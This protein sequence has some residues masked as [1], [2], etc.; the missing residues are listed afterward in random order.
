MRAERGFD[1][2]GV[3]LDLPAP[4][5]DRAVGLFVEYGLTDR[6][7]LRGKG[8]WQSGEDAFVDYD[9]RGPLE[10]GLVWQAWRDESNAL[11][12]AASYANGGEG[13]NAGYALPGQG[14]HDWE[15]RVA[16]GRSFG[17]TWAT[18]PI[19]V[20]AQ[21]AR[22]LRDGL[23]DE[24]RLDLT[25]GS[26]FAPDWMGLTQAYGGEADGGSRWL[27]TEASLVRDF[28]PWSVQAGWRNTATGRETPE[29]SGPLIALW[30]RF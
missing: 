20:E 1:P 27:T 9:G 18:P 21:V 24:T 19:F 26:R 15:V 22:R 11:S 17:A 3:L 13:R 10:I 7:T 28:G 4:R 14:E 25:L 30:R 12:V 6:L 2:D 23:P 29:A 16:Y 5:R 8:D